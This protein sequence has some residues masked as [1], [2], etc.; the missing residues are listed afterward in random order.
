VS[1]KYFKRDSCE[2]S[3]GTMDLAIALRGSWC[4]SETPKVNVFAFLRH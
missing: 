3:S 4:E 1:L 2:L